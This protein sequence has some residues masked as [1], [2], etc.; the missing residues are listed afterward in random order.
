[1]IGVHSTISPIELSLMIKTLEPADNGTDITQINGNYLKPNFE[2]LTDVKAVTI[3]VVGIVQGVWYRASTR[4]KAKE[5]A[6]TGSVKNLTDG[7]VFIEAEG[8]EKNIYRLVEWCHTGPATAKVDE[9]MVTDSPLK[10]FTD[11]K[12]IRH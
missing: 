9:V 8:K 4:T 10:G 7:S 1:M 2:Y 12:I 11:F 5:L 6:L 3:K